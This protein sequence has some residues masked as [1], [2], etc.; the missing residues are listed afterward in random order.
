MADPT[1]AEGAHLEGPHAEAARALCAAD[2]R[3][4]ALIERVG[5]CRLGVETKGPFHTRGLFAGLAEAIVSQQLSAK[6][7]ETI[8][9][10]VKALAE[11]HGPSAGP[12]API[13]PASVLAIPEADLRGAGLSASK[14]RYLRDL[15]AR[16]HEG[17][18]RLD[19]LAALD[20]EAVIERLVEVKGI[21]RWTAEM[22]LV[23]RL[24][25]LD[26]LPLGDL[27]IQRGMQRLFALRALPS[28][29]HMVR[30]AKPWRP[31]R[32]VACWYLWR[33]N[34]EPSPSPRIRKARG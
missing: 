26:V 6:A 33:L 30:L 19:E 34:E 21:G 25:R 15:A 9:R 10:R 1:I 8:F 24:G 18:L 23:F 27:G 5:P 31:Y 3:L 32:S 20:D 17:S 28:E 7:A 29:K 14:A 11:T 4:A 13:G 2:P 22:F 12:G 16:V